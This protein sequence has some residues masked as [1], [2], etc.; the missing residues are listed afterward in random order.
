LDGLF[1]KELD[2]VGFLGL[3]SSSVFQDWSVLRLDLD[4]IG[5]FRIGWFFVWI[6]I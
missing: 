5:F 2:D 3:D 6:W 4:L 1:S